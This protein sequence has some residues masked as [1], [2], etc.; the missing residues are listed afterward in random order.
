MGS[1]MDAAAEILNIEEPPPG[2]NRGRPSWTAIAALLLSVMIPVCGWMVALSNRVAVLEA[3]NGRLSTAAVEIAA[4]KQELSDF[5][6]EYEQDTV[7]RIV[8]A[9][10][11]AQ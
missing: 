5:R 10:R 6:R 9:G 2:S 3:D 1:A 4:L 11:H 7:N 8:I